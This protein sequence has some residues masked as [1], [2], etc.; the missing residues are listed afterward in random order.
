MSISRRPLLFAFKPMAKERIINT[1]FWSDPFIQ[2]LDPDTKLVY[3]YLLTNERTSICGIYE[4]TE[5]TILFDVGLPGDRLSQSVDRLVQ[6]GKIK[7][8]KNWIN[9]TNFAKHQK[10][11]PSVRQGIE[12]ELKGLPQDVFDRLGTDW[13]QSGLLKLKLKLKLKP[14]LELES[15]GGVLDKKE[16][17]SPTD[18]FLLALKTTDGNT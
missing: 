1:K 15:P 3:L 16:K 11:N 6:A 8:Y 10:S 13:V 17:T 5:K 2:E 18:K 9:L 14:E 12:R 4:I 7:R